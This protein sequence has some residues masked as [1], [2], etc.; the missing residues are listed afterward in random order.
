[1]AVNISRII[2]NRNS[3]T[4]I[5]GTSGNDSIVNGGD[6]VTIKGGKGNDTIDT[7]A[8]YRSVSNVTISG[9]KGNDIVN[10]NSY[11]N[12]KNT[13][14][15]YAS[16]DG[17]DTIFGFDSDDTLHITKGSYETLESGNDFIVKVGKSTITLS[18][19]LNEEYKKV[20][21][22][23]PSGEVSVYNDWKKWNGTKYTDMFENNSNNVALYAKGGEDLIH[24]YGDN[25]TISGGAGND[26]IDNPDGKNVKIYGGTGNDSIYSHGSDSTISGGKGDDNIQNSSDGKNVKIYGDAGNDIIYN[27]GDNAII[28][29]GAGNDLISNGYLLTAT[30][31][32]GAGNDDILSYGSYST[33]S[34]GKGNDTIKFSSYYSSRNLIQYAS[35]DGNDTIVYFNSDDTLHITKG[36]YKVKTS[37]NDVIVTVGKGKITLKNAVGQKIS[38]KN[39]KGKVTTKTYGSSTSA[40][41]ESNNF[42]TADTLDSITKNNLTPTALEKISSTNFENL[43]TENNFVTY[44]DK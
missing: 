28:S 6:N 29:G 23:N 12:S 20:T 5:S 1:M 32:G 35:G 9:G 31:Y 13:V 22:K 24:N 25:V 2:S 43:T 42:V 3:D 39:S 21:I 18:N 14:I 40:L 41:L 33:I 16:G 30:I 34:G 10:L 27:M 44:G 36:S 11:R 37:G 4:L 8:G 15:Q 38:I 7:Y 19:A 26:S 17:N